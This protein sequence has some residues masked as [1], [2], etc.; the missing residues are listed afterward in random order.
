MT[1]YL[2]HSLDIL[3]GYGVVPQVFQLLTQYLDRE[4][5]VVRESG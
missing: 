2:G 1:L 5:I 4:T 3:E